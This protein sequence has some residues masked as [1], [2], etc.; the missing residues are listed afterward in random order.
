MN[1]VSSS[2]AK[3]DPFFWVEPNFGPKIR[4]ELGRVSP[5][6]QKTGPIRSGW[7]QKRFKFGF[8]SIMYLINPNEPDLNQLLG[9]VEAPG[10]ILGLSWIGLGPQGPSLG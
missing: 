3:P 8:N 7:L 5:Q 6:G 2:A 4:V 10:S 9:R 1:V